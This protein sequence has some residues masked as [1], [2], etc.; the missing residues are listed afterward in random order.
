MRHSPHRHG[1]SVPRT[2]RPLPVQAL[3]KQVQNRPT[4][5]ATPFP[6]SRLPSRGS[7]TD[8]H[9]A[10]C[11]SQDKMLTQYLFVFAQVHDDFRIPELL[12]I[13]ELYG[14]EIKFPELEDKD[15]ARPFMIIGLENE[16]HAR[17][18]ARRCVLIRCVPYPPMTT[19]ISHGSSYLDMYANSTLAESPTRRSTNG[20]GWGLLHGNST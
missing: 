2:N 6:K 7:S 20:I 3:D 11:P 14:F 15:T 17:L 16:E 18:L 10:D 4:Y 9:N 5:T 19:H 1:R 13:S 12:S 8:H